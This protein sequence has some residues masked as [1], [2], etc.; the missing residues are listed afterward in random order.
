MVPPSAV[1]RP[2]NISDFKRLR[3]NGAAF[4]RASRQRASQRSTRSAGCAARVSADASTRIVSA[5]P[6]PTGNGH[7]GSESMAGTIGQGGTPEKRPVVP[8]LGA[9]KVE[10]GRAHV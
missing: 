5:A 8:Y 4:P 10:I 3:D 6:A 9:V 7:E 2:S 1:R